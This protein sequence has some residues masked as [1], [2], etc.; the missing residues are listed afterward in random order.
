MSRALVTRG[1]WAALLLAGCASAPPP[2]DSVLEPPDEVAVER[3][4][5]LDA[6]AREA[7]RL[8]DEAPNSVE[9]AIAASHA[10]FL[11]ADERVQ[12][13]V[14]AELEA[15]APQSLDDVLDAEDELPDEVR[16][17]VESLTAAGL[18]HARRALTLASEDPSARLHVALNLSLFTWSVG[19][20]RALLD[21]L[22]GDSQEAMAAAIEADPELDAAA[23][24]RLRGRF[25]S[26][27]PWPY[28]DA[29]AAAQ[30]LRRATTIAPV[31]LN[32]L[33]LGDALHEIGDDVGAHAQWRASL[34][35]LPDED[36]A[37]L[38]ELHRELARRRIRL[39]EGDEP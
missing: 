14:L 4:V 10:L 27:A 36:T 34:T 3:E 2:V 35:A 13:G 1:W 8:A 15:H 7:R 25:L 28:G 30:L 21:G 24:L 17:E 16:R 23:P 18:E 22:V 9:R 11:A 26:R 29:E 12:R 37:P 20:T 19:R 33:F 31:P 32:H 5:D 39:A 6:S 38:V